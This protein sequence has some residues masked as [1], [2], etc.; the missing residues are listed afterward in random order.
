MKSL[1]Y[2]MHYGKEFEEKYHAYEAKARAV[3]LKISKQF[4][5]SIYGE[6]C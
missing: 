3:K 6:K 1:I 2:M 5:Q 4:Q